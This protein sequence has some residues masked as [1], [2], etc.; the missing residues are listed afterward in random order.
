MAMGSCAEDIIKNKKIYK[1]TCDLLR[2]FKTISLV[3]K[4]KK[5]LKRRAN[6]RVASCQPVTN[7]TNICLFKVHFK[8]TRNMLR[9]KNRDSELTSFQCLYC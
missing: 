2:N 8:R 9:V 7:P 6:F 5:C 1:K 3:R 4:P